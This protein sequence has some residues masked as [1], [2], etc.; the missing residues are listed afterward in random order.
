M[1]LPFAAENPQT[2]MHGGSTRVP[3]LSVQQNHSPIVLLRHKTKQDDKK[4]CVHY[5]HILLILVSL[6]FSRL[7]FTNQDFSRVWPT[8]RLSPK[9]PWLEK[10]FWTEWGIV[11]L[12][13][14]SPSDKREVLGTLRPSHPS[15]SW[16][17]DPV[18][19]KL[20]HLK[21][22]FLSRWL[23]GSEM[24]NFRWGDS[25][26]T[27]SWDNGHL[28]NAHT[29]RWGWGD[30]H[31]KVFE[32]N[33]TS[34]NLCVKIQANRTAPYSWTALVK[35]W[36]GYATPWINFSLQCIQTLHKPTKDQRPTSARLHVVSICFA[37]NFFTGLPSCNAGSRGGGVS[38]PSPGQTCN[39]YWHVPGLGQPPPLQK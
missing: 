12:E 34:L 9:F 33:Q 31:P 27:H 2:T 1:L 14:T 17:D 29:R 23:S 24:Q 5:F 16:N 39:T 35:T 15:V 6:H 28:R 38:C 30:R 21:V 11:Y 8:H 19:T 22:A 10:V 4:K 7:L 20:S 25:N 32:V 37:Q 3:G 13:L 36:P 18:S 26:Q